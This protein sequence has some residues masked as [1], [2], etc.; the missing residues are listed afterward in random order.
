[1]LDYDDAVMILLTKIGLPTVDVVT[2][3]LSVNKMLSRPD[4]TQ[5]EVYEN[6]TEWS[7]PRTI[8]YH[9]ENCSTIQDPNDIYYHKCIRYSKTQYR[10][11][12]FED[13]KSFTESERD[14]FILWHG[15]YRGV[16]PN[17]YLVAYTMLF[18]MILSWLMTIPHFLRVEKTL[19]QR[20][21]AL[22]F[23]I[24]M[25]WPQY[26]GFRLLWLAYWVKDK[27]KFEQENTHF[28]TTL[29]HL[30]KFEF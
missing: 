25:S 18:F 8:K 16:D 30:G 29:S 19:I 14:Q 2:D 26:R 28:E 13:W 20:L 3:G 9:D 5:F 23:L 11:F 17:V 27:P 21:K 4:K 24:L 10:Q 1:M 7:D 15:R 22:P 12:T 6:M